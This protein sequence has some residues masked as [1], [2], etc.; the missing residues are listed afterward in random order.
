[1]IFNATTKKLHMNIYINCTLPK[2]CFLGKILKID[3]FW[4][5]HNIMYGFTLLQT[6]ESFDKE[7]FL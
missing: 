5:V 3:Y 7:K 4:K 1:M 2:I 6:K